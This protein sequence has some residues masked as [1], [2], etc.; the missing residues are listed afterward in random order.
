MFSWRKT[1]L[2]VLICLKNTNKFL[3]H[4]S[5]VELY[6]RNIAKYFLLY[7]YCLNAVYRL[8]YCSTVVPIIVAT[9]NRGHPQIK[10]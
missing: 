5:I 10:P 3:I 1:T 4:F 7:M 6:Q 8:Q 2:L 9:L